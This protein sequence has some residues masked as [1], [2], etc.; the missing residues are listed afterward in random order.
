MTDDCIYVVKS[1]ERHLEKESEKLS[2]LISVRSRI[3][4]LTETKQQN[5]QFGWKR[6]KGVASV[7]LGFVTNLFP[8]FQSPKRDYQLLQHGE[9]EE[10]ICKG[11]GENTT[12]QYNQ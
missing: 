1:A 8:G 7:G 3:F 5:G 4:C 2:K 12:S 9:P 11:Q 6:F 10:R